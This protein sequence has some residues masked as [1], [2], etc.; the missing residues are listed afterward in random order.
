MPK[1]ARDLVAA[2]STGV[3]SLSGE[4]RTL[5]ARARDGANDLALAVEALDREIASLAGAADAAEM[6]RLVA[7][8][9]ALGAPSVDEGSAKS[10]MRDMFQKQLDLLRGFASRL[11]ELKAKRA[12]LLEL[13]RRLWRQAIELPGAVNDAARTSGATDRI[14]TLCAEIAGQLGGTSANLQATEAISEAPTIE[15]S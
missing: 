4:A 7:K 8:L 14:R 10:Q 13:L 15:R 1:S 11:E 6:D 12:R 5:G 2:I 3:S 9:E